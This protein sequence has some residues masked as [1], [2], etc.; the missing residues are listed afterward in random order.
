MKN[1][2]PKRM[3]KRKKEVGLTE[4]AEAIF[5]PSL[6]TVKDLA[7]NGYQSKPEE[8]ITLLALQGIIRIAILI[9]FCF[10]F[11][12]FYPLYGL[13]HGVFGLQEK[14]F[15]CPFSPTPASLILSHPPGP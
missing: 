9:L 11:S 12:C 4:V 7:G 13:N 6:Q 8:F 10:S 1:F 5:G 3:K 14:H 2:R 15:T